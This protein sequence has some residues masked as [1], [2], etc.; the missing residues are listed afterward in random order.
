MVELY[1][2]RN[3]QLVKVDLDSIATSLQWS[4][5][6]F[7]ESERRL[8]AAVI[9]STQLAREFSEDPEWLIVPGVV[10]HTE[11]VISDHERIPLLSRE[12]YIDP[13]FILV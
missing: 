6:R 2:G 8:P 5:H 9:M 11:V 1:D 3:Q 12:A 10:Y 4:I 7:W 13:F